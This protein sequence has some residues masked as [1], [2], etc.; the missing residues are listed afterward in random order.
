MLKV[1]IIY[2]FKP[3]AWVS[4]QKIVSNL[5]KAYEVNA[6]DIEII[7][8]HYSEY[9]EDTEYYE[10]A[11]KAR[12]SKPDVVI[13]L[14]HKPHPIYIMQW[15]GNEFE[16]MGHTPDYIFHLYGDFTLTFKHWKVFEKM[17][18]DKKTLWY[19]ASRRQKA[20]LTEFIPEDQLAICP[21]PVDDSEFGFD[22][23]IRLAARK[24]YGWSDKEVIFIFTGRLS[25]Q[26]RIHQLI[27]AFAK[28]RNET[29]A[30]AK[31]VF[32]GDT[33]KIGEPW[34]FK[35][36][37]EGEYFHRL[38]KVL[39]KLPDEEKKYFEF[40]G[41]RPNKELTAYYNAADCLVNI[42]VH[43]DEDY[44]MSCAEA[45]ACGLPLILTDWAGFEG[46]VQP[47]LEEA[48]KL[49][50]VKIA[51]KGKLI[52]IKSLEKELS[53]MYENAKGF[54]RSLIQKN[55]LKW[56]GIENAAQ[57]VKAGLKNLTPFKGFTETLH[58]AAESELYNR[59]NTFTDM[60]KHTFNKL[61]MQVYRHYVR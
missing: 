50:P 59:S 44:G 15:L 9:L 21:F 4:C 47:G 27:P 35:G 30:N 41:F 46:F 61:Y 60:K 55:S 40:H 3:S 45:L 7:P 56:T 29:K 32:V 18:K 33:D 52:H 51:P 11:R 8:I 39:N 28:W 58:K 24:S 48:I 43:N 49:V 16:E 6:K 42:S 57:I 23:K 26:K 20:M 12:D 14:D 38:Q 54:N 53:F 25:Q 2:S 5:I 34:L 17:M 22:E 19:A 13:F 31:M 36:E 37:Y 1:C 10:S